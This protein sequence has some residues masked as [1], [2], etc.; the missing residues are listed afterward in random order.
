MTPELQLKQYK[1]IVSALYSFSENILAVDFSQLDYVLFLMLS[2]ALDILKGSRASFLKYEKNDNVLRNRKTIQYKNG[3]LLVEDHEDKLKCLEIYLDNDF[4]S[5]FQKDRRMYV[6]N[7]AARNKFLSREI[8][9]I[10]NINSAHMIFYP[11]YFQ[12]DFVGLIEIVR[13]NKKNKF[14]ELDQ[15]FLKI[16]LNFCSSLFSNIYLYEWAIRDTLTDC[17]AMTYFNKALDEYILYEKR[18]NETFC[19]LMLDIDDFKKINDT[20]GHP[21]GDKAIL[22]FVEMIRKVTRN[23]DLLGRYG[24]DEFCLILRKC[25]LK[26]AKCTAARILLELSNTKLSLKNEKINLSTSIGIAIYGKHGEDR[27][28]LI[29]SADTALYKAKQKGKNTYSVYNPRLK[30]S[31][32]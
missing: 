19:I 18:Y 13:E 9:N 2:S 30:S 8:D 20:Y 10:L 22:F 15:K 32:K 5:L 21:A 27:K 12:D 6:L 4:R 24:G 16:L 25:T 17:F 1:K 28:T 3:S 7:N 31:K 23:N 26:G 29:E 11:V 14:N